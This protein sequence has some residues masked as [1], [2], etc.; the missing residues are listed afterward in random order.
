M[1][2]KL[3]LNLSDLGEHTPCTV[4]V[5]PEKEE[6]LLSGGEK[7]I[8]FF[9][10]A[11]HLEQCAQQFSLV[12]NEDG[13]L[14]VIDFADLQRWDGYRISAYQK[15]EIPAGQL[16]PLPD[17]SLDPSFAGA[18]GLLLRVVLPEEGGLMTVE[19]LIQAASPSLTEGA[20]T[21][22]TVSFADKGADLEAYYFAFE[23]MEA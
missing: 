18:Q 9:A 4:Q 15:V 16:D 7:Q 21:L 22:F 2:Q 6:I 23:P 17:I 19:Q 3:G 13:G 20:D 11:Q 5:T 14:V 12:L 8:R 1:E 10:A